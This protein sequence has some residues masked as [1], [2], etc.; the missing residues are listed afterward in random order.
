MFDPGMPPDEDSGGEARG[1]RGIEIRDVRFSYTQQSWWARR[2][3]VG[4]RAEF[5]CSELRAHPGLTLV[6]GPNGS[7]KSTMLKLLAG[8]ES[9]ETGT[10][11]IDG[12]DL[13][14]D[15][16]VARSHLAYVPE[17]PDFS[18]YAAVGE[19][20]RLV[21]ALRG[22]P[23]SAR[24]EA[25]ELVGLGG[26]E[27]RSIRELSMGQRRRALYATAFIGCP[28]TIILDEPL[29]ALDLGMRDTFLAWLADRLAENAVIL[30]ST[31][32]IEPFL[33]WVRTAILVRR[34]RA[35]VATPPEDPAEK[36]VQL[37]RWTTGSDFPGPEVENS[38]PR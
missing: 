38:T 2:R 17:Q 8:V 35:A 16:V 21:C 7:G 10:V 20:L 18:P 15:E 11:C 9:P 23:V 29:V 30:I 31:H 36:L 3:G 25:L 4:V 19:V 24:D 33:P 13:W 28:T 6:L 14:K 34:G 22:V 12:H 5:E 1:I 27:R 26:L 37:R 32:E